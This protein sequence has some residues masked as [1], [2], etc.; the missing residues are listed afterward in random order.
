MLACLLLLVL[1]SALCS[2]TGTIVATLPKQEHGQHFPGLDLA[3]SLLRVTTL[4]PLPPDRSAS[5]APSIEV[6]SSD[7]FVGDGDGGAPSSEAAEARGGEQSNG[8]G[9]N[10]SRVQHPKFQSTTPAEYLE[11]GVNG[12]GSSGGG[13]GVA[14]LN[15]A[16]LSLHQGSTSSSLEPNVALEPPRSQIKQ[17]LPMIQLFIQRFMLPLYTANVSET[18]IHGR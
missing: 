16:G 7:N 5:Q 8:N 14:G 3:T 6:L 13:G 9:A 12:G 15:L 4:P 17:A 18:R 1:S 11:I 10:A 2:Q